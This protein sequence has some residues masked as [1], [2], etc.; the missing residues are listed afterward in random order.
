ML[1][2][3]TGLLDEFRKRTSFRL[4]LAFLVIYALTAG[5]SLS[6][7][8]L[9]P[10]FVYLAK[11]FLEGRVDLVQVPN[12]PYDVTV[13]RGRY[14]VSFPPL[15]ALLMLPFVA[16]AGLGFSDIVF[17]VV[18][19]AL[20]VSL[21]Y[22][23][24]SHV[25]TLDDSNRLWLCVLL[26][27]G[28]PLW[29]CSALGSVWYTAHVAAVAFLCLY[30]GE[31]LGPNR[32]A[33]SGLWLGLAFLARPTV[34]LAFP[35]A[36]ALRSRSSQGSPSFGAFLLAFAIGA[37]P[38]ILGQAAYNWARFGNPIEYG[39]RWMQS[40]S[41]LLERQQRWGQ[42]S[43]R[44]AP[45]NLYTML[46]RPPLVSLSPFR[47]EPS[48]WGMGLLI[49]CPAMA[50]MFQRQQVGQQMHL[51]P[52]LWSSIGLVVVPSLLYFN[53]GSFQFG[54]RF[55]LDWMPLAIALIAMNN[56]HR[57]RSAHKL[58][59]IA[60]ILMHCWGILWMYPNFNGLPWHLQFARTLASVVP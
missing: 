13:F 11:S 44:F 2:F 43:L 24:L 39:Y 30:L 15:P 3:L 22:R 9:A 33:L 42:F 20:S 14:Y 45:E 19:G 52:G 41:S 26:G 7:H 27:L 16:V 51:R 58:L 60:S 49:C 35:L 50:L 53:T 5:L 10:H 47:V 18:A 23:A 6:R 38:A 48:P 36:L 31:V 40:P 59:V 54:Y 25:G 55:A 46:V 4:F 17:T 32:P 21:M 8:S 34:L 28:T 1:V 56:P 37:A 57:L 29:Y 12:P